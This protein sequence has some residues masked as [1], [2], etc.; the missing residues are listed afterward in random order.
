MWLFFLVLFEI[1]L[2]LVL[3]LAELE[4]LSFLPLVMAK[5]VVYGLM[6]SFLGAFVAFRQLQPEKATN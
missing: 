5:F 3:K 2:I 6:G 1:L 4:G